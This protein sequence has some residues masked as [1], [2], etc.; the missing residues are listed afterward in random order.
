MNYPLRDHC[1]C[2]GRAVSGDECKSCH[3]QENM[4]YDEETEKIYEATK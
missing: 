2:A 3:S 1:A 4:C